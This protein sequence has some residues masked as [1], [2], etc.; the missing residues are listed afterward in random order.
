MLAIIV[1]FLFIKVVVTVGI[2]IIVTVESIFPEP[3]IVGHQGS[4]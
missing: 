4:W 2:L 1:V 3:R